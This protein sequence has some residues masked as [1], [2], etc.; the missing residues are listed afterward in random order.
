ML[1]DS[2]WI[3][4]TMRLLALILSIAAVGGCGATAA[5]NQFGSLSSFDALHPSAELHRLLAVKLATDINAKYATTVST[6]PP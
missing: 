1:G 6:T 5:P 4:R 2:D 3:A